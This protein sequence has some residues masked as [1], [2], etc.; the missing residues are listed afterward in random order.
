MESRSKK[1]WLSE[2]FSLEELTYSLT[3]VEHAIDNEPSPEAK[4]SLQHL[5]NCLLEPLRQLYEKPIAILSGYR[6]K[7]VNRLVGGVATSQHVKGEAADCYTPEGPAKLLELLLRSGLPFDQAILYKRRKFLHIS[8]K[9]SGK[10]RMQVILC[11]LCVIFLLTGCGARRTVAGTC[12]E[13]RRD[14]VRVSRRDSL[15]CVANLEITDSLSWEL[16][17]VVYLP[18]DSSGVQYLQSVTTAK[19]VR[20]CSWTDSLLSSTGS[21]TEYERLATENLTTQHTARSSPRSPC[22]PLAGLVLLLL[23]CLWI[24]CK[25]RRD[26]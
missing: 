15:I 11:M 8:L 25:L 12:L 21:H 3:A 6:N 20:I 1:T 5:T 18:P 9:A 16:E 4:S 10:N 7:E 24:V 14:S 26:K 2:H 23:F 22:L 19:A 13:E 17:Q